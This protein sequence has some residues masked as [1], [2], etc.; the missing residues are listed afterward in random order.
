MKKSLYSALAIGLFL[1]ITVVPT[2]ALSQVVDD[3]AQIN[4]NKPMANWLSPAAIT[5][6]L[7]QQGFVIVDGKHTPICGWIVAYDRNTGAEVHVMVNPN[8]GKVVATM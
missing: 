6:K 5:V 2:L 1:S 4:Y 7:Q 3:A 8:T